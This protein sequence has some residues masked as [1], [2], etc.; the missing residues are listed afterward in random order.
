MFLALLGGLAGQAAPVAPPPVAPLS[1]VAPSLGGDFVLATPELRY[2]AMP[3]VQRDVTEVGWFFTGLLLCGSGAVVM[4]VAAVGGSATDNA[5]ID[6]VFAWT[7]VFGALHFL[8]GASMIGLELTEGRSARI[9]WT[10]TGFAG[11][12]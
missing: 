8:V 2:D 6:Q 1:F 12:F 11:Q 9:V 4:G 7:G 10:G 3:T 5:A